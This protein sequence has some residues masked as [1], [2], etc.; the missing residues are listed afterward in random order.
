MIFHKRIFLSALFIIAFCATSLFSQAQIS[1]DE[2]IIGTFLGNEK[3]NYYGSNPPDNLNINWKH[4]LGEGITI[5][6]TGP[7]TLLWKGSGWTGQPLLIKENNEL[8]LIQASLDHNLKKIKATTGELVWEYKFDDVLKGT[9]TIWE[10]NSA[11]NPEDRFIILQGSRRGNDKT[12]YSKIVPSFR[13]ISYGS[14]KELWRLNIRKTRSYSRDMD[15]SPLIINDTI[16]TP[17]EN[18]TFVLIDLKGKFDVGR[19]GKNYANIIQESLLY[20]QQDVLKHGGNLVAESSPARINDH[21]YIPAGSGWVFGYDLIKKRIDWEYFIG[22]DIDGSPV[23]TGDDCILVSIEKQYIDGNGGVIKLN[24]AKD[25]KNAVEWFFPT[26]NVDYESWEGG[27]IGSASVN[28]YYNKSGRKNLA[29]FIALDG[30]LYL[31]DYSEIDNSKGQVWG[32]NNKMKFPTP[33]LLD[34]FDIG[35]SIS[36]PIIVDNKIIAASYSGLY[37]FRITENYTLQLIDKITGFGF[38]ATPIVYQGK[39]YIGAKDGY[40]YC[41]GN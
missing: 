3:R 24:P 18:S 22:S 15:A 31:V 30:F 19:D 12:M 17:L 20:K 16:Y 13:A 4:Y 37:L 38:E 40:L 21:L 10:N 27:V 32:P 8:Y 5:I 7:D 11:K 34:K 29:S 35:P 1:D 6:S 28:D 39:L 14:G 25:P 33:K 23:V 26:E 2:V 9:G 36:T 41:L